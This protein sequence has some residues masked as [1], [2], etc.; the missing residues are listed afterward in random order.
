MAREIIN[1][2]TQPNDGTGDTLRIMGDK[3]NNNFEELYDIVNHPDLID[4]KTVSQELQFLKPTFNSILAATEGTEEITNTLPPVSGDI[5]NTE[6]TQFVKNKKFETIKIASDN[7]VNFYNIIPGNV[8]T[9]INLNIPNL[10][11][12]DNFVFTNHPQTLNNKTLQGPVI[13]DAIYDS[14]GAP[15]LSFDVIDGASNNIVI[16]NVLQGNAPKLTVVSNPTQFT[17]ADT[18]VNLEIEALG[19]AVIKTNSPLVK[20]VEVINFS[21]GNEDAGDMSVLKDITKFTGTVD[22]I[23]ALP[24]PTDTSNILH[25]TLINIS[26]NNVTIT[27][28]NFANATSIVMKPNSIVDLMFVDTG[29]MLNE[30]KFYDASETTA[31]WYVE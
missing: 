10:T 5:L 18:D 6:A 16:S 12:S 24:N 26:N 17:P 27:P 22:G 11:D 31:L 1:L 23:V 30:P 25:K 2:G 21:T 15:I 20:D 8:T 13:N 7:L 19:D 9:D 4:L 29:W 3:V 28:T 14:S